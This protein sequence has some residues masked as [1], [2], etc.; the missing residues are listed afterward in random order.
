MKPS[1]RNMV[2]AGVAAVG[3][4]A[5]SQPAHAV[6]VGLELSLLLDTSGSVDVNEFNLQRDGYVSAFNSAAVQTAIAGITGGIAVNLIQ[7]SGAAQQ[8]Q[9]LGWTHIDSA[10]SAGNFAT[11]ISGFLYTSAFSGQTAPGSAINFAAPL[12]TGNGFEGDRLVID[13]SGDGAQNAG[14]DTLTARNAALAGSVTQDAVDAING[15]P[16]LGESGLLSFYQN[17]IQGGANSFTLPAASFADFNAAIQ[18][19]LVAEITGENPVPEPA[20]MALLGV[21]LLGLGY[22]RRR[23]S[24]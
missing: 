8:Q 12:F 17:N 6:A 11:A 10:V 16:I 4:A 19:K 15:L 20:T 14:A 2:L 13:V 7:W 1:F 21:G 9:V 23:K 24:V 22:A 18:T 5:A 3:L